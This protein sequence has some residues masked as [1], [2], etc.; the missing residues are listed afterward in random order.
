[1]EL[2]KLVSDEPTRSR[3]NKDYNELRVLLSQDGNASEK[4]A[5]LI[6]DFVNKK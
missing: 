1:M 3:L 5:R 2:K 6:V 4:A